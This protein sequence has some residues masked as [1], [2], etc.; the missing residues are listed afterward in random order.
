MA[1][2][3]KKQWG[4][5]WAGLENLNRSRMT[6]LVKQDMDLM[7]LV[8]KLRAHENS[9]VQ[10]SAK[11]VWDK[12]KASFDKYASASQKRAVAAAVPEDKEMA[13]SPAG[14]DDNPFD[15]EGDDDGKGMRTWTAGRFK[16]E[17]EFQKV[18]GQTVVLKNK[19]GKTVRVPLSR[20]SAADKKLAEKLSKSR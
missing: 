19:A 18:Q 1:Q 13:D 8:G 5:V 14:D 16:V 9:K 4:P 17:A 7:T 12:W 15:V 2:L 11:K 3:Q 6:G 10:K 20:L